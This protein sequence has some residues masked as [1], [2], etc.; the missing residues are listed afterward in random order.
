MLSAEALVSIHRRMMQVVEESGGA[1]ERVYACPHRPDQGCACRKP[2]TGLLHQAAAEL[3][4]D[5][6][7]SVLMGDSSSDVEA[8]RRAGCQPIFVGK[9]SPELL[10]ADLLVADQLLNAVAMLIGGGDDGAVA[11]C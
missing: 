3:K 2:R 8:A 9:A 11:A 6:S 1:I 10:H 7:R 5:L 4:I